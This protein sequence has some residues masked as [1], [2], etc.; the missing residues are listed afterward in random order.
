MFKVGS[1]VARRHTGF[2]VRRVLVARRARRD[3][4]VCR[5]TLK[6]PVES[7]CPREAIR[8]VRGAVQPEAITQKQKI[9]QKIGGGGQNQRRSVDS[10]SRGSITAV[11]APPPAP[12]PPPAAE[13]PT[14]RWH[15]FRRRETSYTRILP[16]RPTLVRGR[17]RV[18]VLLGTCGR[19]CGV[20]V[21]MSGLWCLRVF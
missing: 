13:L 18:R 3:G 9:E 2:R 15:A 1:L 16:C 8:W 7:T 21:R 10:T 17:A 4:A 11:P 6:V 19:V 12:L 14:S 5:Q 20:G